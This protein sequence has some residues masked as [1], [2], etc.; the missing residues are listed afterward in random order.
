MT[1]DDNKNAKDDEIWWKRM[2]DD[3][4]WCEMMQNDADDAR[5]CKMMQDDARWW[6]DR[7]IMKTCIEDDGAYGQDLTKDFPNMKDSKHMSN[8]QKKY[9]N[10]WSNEKWWEHRKVI[11]NDEECGYVYICISQHTSVQI[12]RCR[13]LYMN[14]YRSNLRKRLK[15]NPP[16]PPIRPGPKNTRLMTDRTACGNNYMFNRLLLFV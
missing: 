7:N 3:E 12:S 8:I 15:N 13:S 16:A 1:K 2:Q 14:I 4:R 6:K 11:E 9:E 5:W 10:N